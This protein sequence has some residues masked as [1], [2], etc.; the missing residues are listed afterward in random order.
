MPV[1]VPVVL[2]GSKAAESGEPSSGCGFL[3][4]ALQ[5]QAHRVV[6]IGSGEAV[7]AQLQLAD[8][9]PEKDAALIYRQFGGRRPDNSK[10]RIGQSEHAAM[11]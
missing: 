5:R 10:L 6:K 7:A 9:A 11:V 3:D 2:G 4:Q 1:F 8:K